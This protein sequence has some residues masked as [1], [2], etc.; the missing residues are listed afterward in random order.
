MSVD[1]SGIEY[2]KNRDR[3]DI[4]HYEDLTED[5]IVDGFKVF[6]TNDIK[7]T[8]LKKEIDI[9]KF[10]LREMEAKMEALSN[11]QDVIGRV[12]HIYNNIPVSEMCTIPSFESSYGRYTLSS[13]GGTNTRYLSAWVNANIPDDVKIS[14]LDIWCFSLRDNDGAEV[15]FLANQYK[16]IV[17]DD[18]FDIDFIKFIAY[19]FIVNKI[20][21][22]ELYRNL[23]PMVN[24]YTR[25]KNIKSLLNS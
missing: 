5:E 18:G 8:E 1:V 10:E 13:I 17:S 7:L 25:D 21:I 12:T 22:S 20:P 11:Y 23:E 16:C 6:D 9:K 4:R 15:T 2:I 3:F 24:I 19:E 14:K